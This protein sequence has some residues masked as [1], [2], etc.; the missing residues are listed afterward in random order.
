MV[1]RFQ[2]SLRSHQLQDSGL[3]SFV[4]EIENMSYQQQL[5]TSGAPDA[6]RFVGADPPQVRLTRSWMSSYHLLHA[7]ATSASLAFLFILITLH[8]PADH[9]SISPLFLLSAA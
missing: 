3:F 4:N 1:H 5:S 8:S 6:C 2:L 7:Q 9:P